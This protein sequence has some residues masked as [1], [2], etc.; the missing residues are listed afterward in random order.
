[1]S[2][3][4]TA[5]WSELL[6]LARYL[7]SRPRAVYDFPWQDEGFGVRASVDADFVGCLRARPITCGGVCVRGARTAKHWPT[8]QKT[9]ALSSGEAELAGIVKGAAEGVG[10]VSVAVDI[11]F[12]A[13]P[14]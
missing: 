14:R 2:A 8:T 7:A 6:R 1:M 10:I 3:P 4:A 11:G 9:I 13:G 12:S 5:D